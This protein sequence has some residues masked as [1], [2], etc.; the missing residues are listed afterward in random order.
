MDTGA[1]VA[2]S[3]GNRRVRVLIREALTEGAVL[4]VPAIVVTETYRGNPQDVLLNRLL[5]RVVID[6]A[7]FELAKVAGRLLAVTGTS[8][9]PD[10]QV[11]AVALRRAPCIIL[12]SDEQDITAL[13]NGR[14][15]IRV[16]NV[17]R[18]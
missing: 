10:A 4:I 3:K 12:T 16:V 14:S 13:V 1:L 11:V 7:G 18:L 15:D 8:N 17:D 9:A 2:E 5:D 6:V